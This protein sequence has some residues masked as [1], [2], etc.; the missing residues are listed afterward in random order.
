MPNVK[1]FLVE[2]VFKALVVG[3]C[4]TLSVAQVVSPNIQ[5]EEYDS[6]LKIVGSIVDFVCFELPRCI[7][8]DLYFLHE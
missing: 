1:L 8:D 3:K 4:R 5:G 2:D 7:R 6:K